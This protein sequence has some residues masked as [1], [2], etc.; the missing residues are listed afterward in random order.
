MAAVSI[1]GLTLPVLR[2]LAS[3]SQGLKGFI[4]EN[5]LNLVML[6]FI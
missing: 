3:K 2:L 4:F 1:V 6:V 5:D